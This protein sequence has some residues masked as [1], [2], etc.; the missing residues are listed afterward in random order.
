MTDDHS[1]RPLGNRRRRRAPSDGQ[2]ERRRAATE[3]TFCPYCARKHAGFGLAK[4]LS[5]VHRAV[6]TLV[7]A[8]LPT[9]DDN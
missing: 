8:P 5:L 6:M 3:P 9:N 2:A 7:Q 4:H 1:K